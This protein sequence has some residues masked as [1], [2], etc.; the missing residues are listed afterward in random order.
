MGLKDKEQRRIALQ[1]FLK[2]FPTSKRA[3]AASEHL[4]N[5]LLNESSKDI[6]HIHTLAQTLID[7]AG[8]EARPDGENSIAYD[9]AEA[10]PN[11]IDLQS[12]EIWARDAVE[13]QTLLSMTSRMTKEWAERKLPPP[14]AQDIHE[15]WA[16]NRANFLQTLADVYVHEDKLPEAAKTLEEALALSPENGSVWALQGQIAHLRRD[17]ASALQ[18]LELAS[19][20]ADSDLTDGQRALLK[21]LYAGFNPDRVGGL[22]AEVERIY[23]GLPQPVTPTAYTGPTSGHTV[24]VEMYS[25]SGCQPCLATDYAFDGILQS[26]PRDRVVALTFGIHSPLPDPL[27]NPDSLGRAE[28]TGAYS[29]PTVRVD[30]RPDPLVGGYKARAQRSFEEISKSIGEELK[31]DSGVD[32]YLT[33]GLNPAHDITAHADIK[34]RDPVAL[35]RV[36]ST[37]VE[38]DVQNLTY[39]SERHVSTVPEKPQ[40][41]Y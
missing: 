28:F 9:L 2:S 20:Y 33:A 41:S 3:Y 16:F 22:D 6:G 27:A 23:S 31:I 7:Q 13:Q 26:F 8:P 40:G 17:D 29:A 10:V 32:L 34:V 15:A 19:A 36:L 38:P 35:Q 1:E 24:L 18:K 25:G 21:Q 12:A 11:G 4:L 39:A 5:L 14:T 30:G 37:P